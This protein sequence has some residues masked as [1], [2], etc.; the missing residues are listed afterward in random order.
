MIKP[1]TGI[2]CKKDISST[3]LCCILIPWKLSHLP[4]S[5][6]SK[7][8]VYLPS[9]DVVMTKILQTSN[10]QYV[11]IDFFYGLKLSS[12]V[13]IS[14]EKFISRLGFEAQISWFPFRHATIAPSKP[15]TSLRLK[16]LFSLSPLPADKTRDSNLMLLIDLDGAMVLRVHAKQL[17][18]R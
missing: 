2:I 10:K 1:L 11:T 16:W 3:F 7:R 4:S 12:T 6:P 18:S 13:N 17:Q 15:A 14:R 8:Y 9:W 5:L